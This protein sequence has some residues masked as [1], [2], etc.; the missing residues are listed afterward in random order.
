MR[1]AQALLRTPSLWA[2]TAVTLP[3]ES[4]TACGV[5]ALPRS[6]FSTLTAVP[7]VLVLLL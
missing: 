1:F 2:Q 6:S 4:M 5:P 3:P 7:Q